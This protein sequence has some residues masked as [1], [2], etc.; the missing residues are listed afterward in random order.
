MKIVTWNICCLP[1]I[2]NLYQ[3]PMCV[4]DKIIDV[5]IS[6]KSDFI[7]LQELFDKKCIERVK[8]R[9]S[10]YSILHDT[11][12]SRKFVNSGLMILSKHKLLASGCE[13]YKAKCGEDRMSCKGF[14]YG[15]YDYNGKNIVVYNTHLN[16]DTPIFNFY[17]NPN[18]VIKKQLTQLFLHIHKASKQY[19][20][21]FI[22]G[23]F[24]TETYF[25][26]TFVQNAFFLTNL[27][28]KGFNANT[29]LINETKTIDHV[30]YITP[31]KSP[32]YEETQKNYNF[33]LYSDH[34]LI[35]KDFTML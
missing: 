15:L 26:Q 4:I 32:V 35:E 3:N 5:L 12:S 18:N 1:N 2:I 14:L 28:I 13:Q 16:N 30:L 10:N 11:T 9:M 7:C 6:Y 29:T 27:T 23:D 8:E 24:N 31:Y 21:I 19:K 22:G 34:F 20:Q 33:S 25:L 17:S